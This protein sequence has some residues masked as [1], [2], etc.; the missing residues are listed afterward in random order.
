MVKRKQIKGKITRRTS[1]AVP[2][3][4][5]AATSKEDR[6]ENLLWFA[7]VSPA[8]VWMFRAVN[9]E[10]L[11]RWM[12][13]MEDRCNEF[14]Q[15]MQEIKMA[16][17]QAEKS[18]DNDPCPIRYKNHPL[19]ETG[20]PQL[21]R[22]AIPGRPMSGQFSSEDAVRARADSE[23]APVAAPPQLK[24]TATSA[25]VMSSR[26]NSKGV[27]GG[28]AGTGSGATSSPAVRKRAPSDVPSFETLDSFDADL[29]ALGASRSPR[30]PAKP[31]SPSPA[32]RAE[33]SGS[34]KSIGGSRSP[35]GPAAAGGGG[36]PGKPLPGSSPRRASAASTREDESDLLDGLDDD[37]MDEKPKK[38]LPPRS[39][40]TPA[41]SKGDSVSSVPA[42]PGKRSASSNSSSSTGDAEEALK[43]KI[44]ALESLQKQFGVLKEEFQ[45]RKAKDKEKD[46]E[47]ERLKSELEEAKSNAG[48]SNEATEAELEDTKTKLKNEA[49]KTAKLEQEVKKLKSDNERLASQ[50]GSAK[51]AEEASKEVEELRAQ[52]ESQSSETEKLEQQVDELK[53]QLKEASRVGGEL[54]REK[55]KRELAERKLQ[56]QEE[57]AGKV[58]EELESL[59]NDMISLE[60]Q[61]ARAKKQ[62]SDAEA[63][64]QQQVQQ[65]S[66]SQKGGGDNKA[67]LQQ[68]ANL[69]AKLAAAES[70]ARSA[71]TAAAVYAQKNVVANVSDSNVR[72]VVKA[73]NAE[74]DELLQQV[75]A[76]RA[77]AASDAGSADVKALRKELVAALKQLE[78]AQDKI[79]AEAKAAASNAPPSGGGGGGGNPAAEKRLRDEINQL[80]KDKKELAAQ[81]EELK[82]EIVLHLQDKEQVRV[83][84][85]VL[86]CV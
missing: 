10:D 52:L 68:V 81:V 48:G 79:R 45:N 75:A 71:R 38:A 36:P 4:G 65:A 34:V 17:Q 8:R 23:A 62:A 33:D 66:A 37:L 70:E 77:A 67:L 43:E 46:K 1:V 12:Y 14:K 2:V 50:A 11:E 16:I 27:G 18:F 20:Y 53:K 80:N 54:E 13:S 78:A 49:K 58:E 24:K 29:D 22:A 6:L 35:R 5:S 55:K 82:A 85:F 25:A 84:S 39:T 21:E 31:T 40:R 9:L 60:D 30:V 28:A 83:L 74:N 76:L 56:E 47:I 15:Q 61:L 41:S 63:K 59:K 86:C 42:V 7:I 26:G 73:L 69:E 3:D 64:L 72:E 51:D 32:R 19:K 44:A 57:S